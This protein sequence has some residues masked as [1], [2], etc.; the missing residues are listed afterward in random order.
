VTE[1]Y[2]TDTF[3]GRLLYLTK[4][5]SKVGKLVKRKGETEKVPDTYC[6]A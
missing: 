6:I 4:P 3:V 1:A 2:E 5:K